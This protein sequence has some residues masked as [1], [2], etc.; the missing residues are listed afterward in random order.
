MSTSHD[1]ASQCHTLYFCHILVSYY[2]FIEGRIWPV[3]SYNSTPLFAGCSGNISGLVKIHF[4]QFQ[5][6]YGN[7]WPGP[8]VVV[9]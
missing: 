1:A 6:N 8:L 3:I 5:H 9:G 2:K 7:N 4:Y